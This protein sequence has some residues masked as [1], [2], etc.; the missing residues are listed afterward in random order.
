MR[1]AKAM[2]KERTSV[3]SNFALGGQNS[4]KS[5]RV[6]MGRKGGDYSGNFPGNRPLPE[7]RKGLV[8]RCI[9]CEVRK[10]KTPTITPIA[11]R[12]TRGERKELEPGKN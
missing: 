3:S 1:A 12:K 5:G 8:L 11:A 4:V 7:D 2:S 6:R 9:D 10:E